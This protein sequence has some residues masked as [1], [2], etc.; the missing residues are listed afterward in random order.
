MLPGGGFAASPN[1]VPDVAKAKEFSVGFLGFAVDWQNRY[2]QNTPA[3][4]QLSRG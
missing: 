2:T 3:Y 4:M 1:Q